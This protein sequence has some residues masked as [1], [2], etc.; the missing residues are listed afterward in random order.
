MHV[1]N[2]LFLEKAIYKLSFKAMTGFTLSPSAD[3]DIRKRQCIN[4]PRIGEA[5]RFI[6]P[7]P[8]GCSA[9]ARPGLHHA[10]LIAKK[11]RV[12]WK[13][14]ADDVRSPGFSRNL[15]NLRA[16]AGTTNGAGLISR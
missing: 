4:L 9:H 8:M 7:P 15:K 14:P 13:Y 2:C 6:P 11:N 1:I 5:Y 12:A 3:T 10:A 16:D